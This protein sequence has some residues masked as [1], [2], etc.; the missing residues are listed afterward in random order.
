M[1]PFLLLIL[2][3]CFQGTIVLS[4]GF[5]IGAFDLGD[6]F[7][8]PYA[9]PFNLLVVE[10]IET[11]TNIEP[12]YFDD[13]SSLP[14]SSFEIKSRLSWPQYKSSAD[15]TNSER[16]DEEIKPDEIFEESIEIHDDQLKKGV[17]VVGLSGS[18]LYLCGYS[19]SLHLLSVSLKTW[20]L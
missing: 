1:L 2:T 15:S 20:S 14:F 12:A 7:L 13:E 19:G 16:S 17:G 18:S 5:K 3:T 10:G 9:P 6:E 4:N 8:K 11:D